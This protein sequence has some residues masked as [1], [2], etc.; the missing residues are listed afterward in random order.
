MSDQEWFQTIVIVGLI[1]NF[2]A[3][4]NVSKQVAEVGA[5]VQQIRDRRP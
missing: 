2:M 3:I 4:H 1:V 5:A